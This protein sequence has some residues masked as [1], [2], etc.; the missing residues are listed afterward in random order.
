MWNYTPSEK[1]QKGFRFSPPDHYFREF[2]ATFEHEETDDQSK[3]IDDV[4]EDLSSDKTMDRLVCGDVGFGKT[5]IAIRAAFKVVSDG[6][7]VAFLV[8][9]TVL[10]EQHFETFK[11]RMSPHGVSVGILSRFKT[12]AEQTKTVAEARSGKNQY[13]HRY[14]PNTAKRCGVRRPGGW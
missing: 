14:P 1:Y 12:R 7:Q 6:K 11:K 8:P 2:E 3:A 5:E 4:L 9:T 13:P 10:A